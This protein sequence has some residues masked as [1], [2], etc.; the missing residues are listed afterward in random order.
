MYL[1]PE[2]MDLYREQTISEQLNQLY[3]NL[4]N[5]NVDDIGFSY[6]INQINTKSLQFLSI[7]NDLI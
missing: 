3:L 6:W 5:R 2:C 4:F 1:Q 7:A